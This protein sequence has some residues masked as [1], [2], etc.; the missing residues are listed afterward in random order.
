MGTQQRKKKCQFDS[1][2]FLIYKVFPSNP[3]WEWGSDSRS[4]CLFWNCFLNHCK[5]WF[6]LSCFHL[7]FLN[8][9]IKS[10]F[11]VEGLCFQMIYD[12]CSRV[13]AF[14]LFRNEGFEV[15]ELP[16]RLDHLFVC[17]FVSNM[18]KWC[19]WFGKTNWWKN[20]HSER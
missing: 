20:F 1:N 7:S 10:S 2:Y 8:I 9:L 12:L 5:L 13:P 18:P 4:F 15:F 16:L 14:Y 19:K 3:I 6:V 11:E 17:L